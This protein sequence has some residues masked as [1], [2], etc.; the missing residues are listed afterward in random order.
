VGLL[1][2]V[3]LKGGSAGLLAKEFFALGVFAALVGTL[4]TRS[5]HKRL[6]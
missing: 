6:G 1:K 2:V 3:F 4:A 5:F